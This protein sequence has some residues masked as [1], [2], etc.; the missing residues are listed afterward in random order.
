MD[1]AKAR[2]SKRSDFKRTWVRLAKEEG[3]PAWG[4][5]GEKVLSPEMIRRRHSES[6]RENPRATN[7][8]IKIAAPKAEWATLTGFEPVLPP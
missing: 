2:H 5:D 3:E 6:K 4:L 7:P 1:L 8:A